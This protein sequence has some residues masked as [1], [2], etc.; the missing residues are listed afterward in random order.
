MIFIVINK[1]TDDKES[2]PEPKK[3]SGFV[4]TA[5]MDVQAHIMIKDKDTGK[6]LVNKRG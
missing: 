6:V 2:K 5:H 3:E 1:E 4:D